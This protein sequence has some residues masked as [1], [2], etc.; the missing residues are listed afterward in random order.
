[1]VHGYGQGMQHGQVREPQG[2]Q[3][4][5][6]HVDVVAIQVVQL[7]GQHLHSSTVAAQV[8]GRCRLGTAAWLL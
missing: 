5:S 3:G 8:C 6:Q 4:G 7:E 2:V 1:M